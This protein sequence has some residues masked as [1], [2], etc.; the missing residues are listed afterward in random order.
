MLTSFNSV[1]I[2]IHIHVWHKNELFLV[3]KV[4]TESTGGLE[5]VQFQKQAHVLANFMRQRLLLK[6]KDTYTSKL[7]SRY[8]LSVISGLNQLIC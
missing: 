3:E 8:H 5:L 4:K 1:I 6:V 7:I 2:F